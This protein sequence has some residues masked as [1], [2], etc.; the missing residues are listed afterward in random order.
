MLRY[1]DSKALVIVRPVKKQF[2][3]AAALISTR[4]ASRLRRP[5]ELLG[6]ELTEAF[7]ARPSETNR[8]SSSQGK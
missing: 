3:I 2:A 7:A 4:R 6:M 8:R 5:I 1:P